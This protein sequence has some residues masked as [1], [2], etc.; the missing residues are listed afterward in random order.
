MTHL[1]RHTTHTVTTRT[2]DNVVIPSAIMVEEEDVCR[3]L[4]TGSAGT[5]H[6]KHA[7]YKGECKIV[8]RFAFYMYIVTFD[9]L[10]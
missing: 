2:L 8:T 5:L 9:S 7:K 10:H 6:D 3:S 1:Y 4:S